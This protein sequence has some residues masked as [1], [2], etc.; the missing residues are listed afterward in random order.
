MPQLDFY[1]AAS[2]LFWL[3]ISFGLLYYIMAKVALPRMDSVLQNRE[4]KRM[5][6]L[7]E[8]DNYQFQAQDI[9]HRCK[10]LLEEA[11]AKAG[12]MLDEA[13]KEAAKSVDESMARLDKDLDKKLAEAQKSIADSQQKARESMYEIAT[14]LSQIVVK[15]VAGIKVNASAAE[16][17]V[18]K[19]SD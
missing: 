9:E 11:H 6:D 2:Q 14:E 12:A 7:E 5:Q 13:R 15:D 4:D 17:A 1:W 3:S 19:S 18:S 8:A 10:K 16:K